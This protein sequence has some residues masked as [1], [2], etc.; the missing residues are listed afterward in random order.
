MKIINKGGTRFEKRYR[1]K[2]RMPK[3]ARPMSSLVVALQ[4]GEDVDFCAID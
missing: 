1:K 4:R 2:A 3:I